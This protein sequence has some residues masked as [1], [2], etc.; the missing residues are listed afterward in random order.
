MVN[1]WTINIQKGASYTQSITV[2][3]IADISSATE[4]RIVIG[5]PGGDSIL[6]AS[7][8][9]GLITGGGPNVRVISLPPATTQTLLPGNYRFD[10]DILWGSTRTERLYAL[11]QCIVQPEV[12]K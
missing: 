8:L 4:W 11:G 5:N 1:K 6:E 10:F 12:P 7:T 2:N 3:G 9:N